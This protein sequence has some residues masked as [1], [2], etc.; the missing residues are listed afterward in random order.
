M[1]GLSCNQP[2]APCS[3]Q[4]P[5]P[6]EGQLPRMP[7]RNLLI[8]SSSIVGIFQV[9]NV[10]SI[11]VV[12]YLHLSDLN[13]SIPILTPKG[14]PFTMGIKSENLCLFLGMHHLSKLF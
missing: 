11:A 1:K 5:F 13:N 14:N 8:A 10:L 3:T 12:H 7:M 9:L 4:T 6:K 2:L